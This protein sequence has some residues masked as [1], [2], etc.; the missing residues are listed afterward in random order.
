MSLSGNSYQVLARKWRPHSFEELVGQ[1]V[2]VL[3]LK[4]ALEHNI[5]HH[6]YLFTGTRGVGKTSLARLLA[7]AMSC[8]QKVSATPCGKCANCL[9]IDQGN[10]PD[11]IEI[12][13]A[14][15]T[16]VE[17]IRDL[18]SQVAYAPLVGRFKIYLIDEVHMLSTHSFNALLKTLEEPPQHVKFLLATTDPQKLPV[19]I[20]SRVLRFNLKALSPDVVVKQ[21]GKILTEEKIAFQPEALSLIAKAAKGSMRDALTV[22]EQALAYSNYKNLEAASLSQLLGIVDPKDALELLTSLIKLDGNAALAKLKALA[23][24]SLDFNDLLDELLLSLQQLALMQSLPGYEKLLDSD[25]FNAWRIGELK[26]LLNLTSAENLQLYY[27]ILL[28]GK[29]DLAFSASPLSGVEMLFL[30]C[31][32]FS[33]DTLNAK[34]SANEKL[35]NHLAGTTTKPA[36]VAPQPKAM[37]MDFP[38]LLKTLPCKGLLKNVLDHCT[39]KSY[40][41]SVLVLELDSAQQALLSPNVTQRLQ[42]LIQDALKQPVTVNIE[43]SHYKEQLATNAAQLNMAHQQELNQALETLQQDQA[44]CAMQKELQAKLE[45]NQIQ[46]TTTAIEK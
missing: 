1:D 41:D 39:Y 10:F 19:T 23:E 28:L 27:Q 25:D 3:A 18:L 30:R 43:I 11:L 16:R 35:T 38:K 17:D 36:P 14:S 15:N 4:H 29:R 37:E 7:K 20:L 6:A 42:K 8:E 24:V 32:A 33:A 9:A 26:K 44:I 13:A 34:A 12:D 31:L 2:A 5:L 46:M 40:Q 45:L 21:L 22:L